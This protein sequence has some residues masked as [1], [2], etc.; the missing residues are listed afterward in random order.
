VHLPQGPSDESVIIHEKA[1]TL[2]AYSTMVLPDRCSCGCHQWLSH[3]W[4]SQHATL[5]A[6]LGYSARQVHPPLATVAHTVSG[7]QVTPGAPTCT[8]SASPASL[9]VCLRC[10]LPVIAGPLSAT[11]NLGHA[12]PREQT[13]GPEACTYF[14]CWCWRHAPHAS[15]HPHKP[16]GQ[17]LGESMELLTTYPPTGNPPDTHTRIVIPTTHR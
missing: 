5:A 7:H 6:S 16:R 9:A 17:F 4:Q 11:Q 10:G 13:A 15:H 1:I 3:C 14:Q 8:A 2:V 12:C